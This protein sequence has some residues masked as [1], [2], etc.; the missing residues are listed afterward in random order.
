M[1]KFI[2]LFLISISIFA[3]SRPGYAE[4]KKELPLAWEKIFPLAY[5]NVVAEDP[6]RH[7]IVM[8]KRSDKRVVW[9]YNF[10][11]FMPKYDRNQ[12]EP[13]ARAEGREIL[14]YFLWEPS[15]V[16]DPYRIQL[17]DLNQNL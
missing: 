4:A 16:E 9:I 5:G 10:K 6:L 3:E 17:G 1:H 13:T 12:N 8:E 7:G 11:V 14:V 2:L 15:R